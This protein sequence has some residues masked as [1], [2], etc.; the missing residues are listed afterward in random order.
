MPLRIVFCMDV[1]TF[2]YHGAVK[3]CNYYVV[4]SKS[5]T[6]TGK[7]NKLILFSQG[8]KTNKSKNCMQTR[9]GWLE[10]SFDLCGWHWKNMFRC[11]IELASN[12]RKIRLCLLVSAVYKL[13]HK[14]TKFSI[15]FCLCS[16]D[17]VLNLCMK[18]VH[19]A[20]SRPFPGIF[21]HESPALEVMAG[22]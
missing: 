14:K 21:L 15:Q 10:K 18:L 9:Q 4:I 19:V 12:S 8:K 7:L 3:P 13:H 22:S 5:R 20:R 17:A 6:I 2:V 16:L 1:T 11:R